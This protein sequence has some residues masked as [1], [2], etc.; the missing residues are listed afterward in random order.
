MRFVS[1]NILLYF[2]LLLLGVSGFFVATFWPQAGG[3]YAF[4]VLSALGG[5]GV[6]IYI[7]HTKRHNKQLVCPVGSNCNVVITSH[8]SK[9]LGVSLEYWGM[10]YYGVLLASYAFLVFAP[11]FLP[12]MLLSG[13]FLLTVSA[14]LFSLYL[15][16]V[17]AFILRQW[18]IWC[19][20][21]AILSTAIFMASLA[22]VDF[23]TAFLAGAGGVIEAIHAL[24]FVLGMGGATAALFLFLSFLRDLDIDDSEART[25]KSM[26][27]L[28]WFGLILTLVSQL[29]RLVIFPEI[30][31][32]SGPF[33]VQTTAL[34]A[35]AVSGA[36]LMIIFAPFLTMIPFHRTD[37]D[38]AGDPPSPLERLRK[39]LFITG[40]VALSSWYFAFGMDF[41]SPNGVT[42]SVLFSIYAAILVVA[43]V[44]ALLCDKAIGRAKL[45]KN[46]SGV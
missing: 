7:R 15:L 41:L 38:K 11:G 25:L 13:L 2:F 43:I 36:V 22:S 32:R 27:E 19:L 6:S 26:S 42:V 30:L 21:S 17:Q 1:P 12:Q 3:F 37:E 23:A 14:F 10:L 35:V 33:V 18:C 45:S 9:F 46:I 28:V 4:I 16:F 34:F 29:A 20:L 24:G 5:L 39:P 40:A 8:Y 31:A 44:V